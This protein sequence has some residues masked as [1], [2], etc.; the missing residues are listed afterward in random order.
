VRTK[1]GES[2][3]KETQDLNNQNEE[4]EEDISSPLNY[5]KNRKVVHEE[6]DQDINHPDIKYSQP[7]DADEDS[8]EPIKQKKGHYDLHSFKPSSTKK[9][10]PS[11]KSSQ[12]IKS[13]SRKYP[14]TKKKT[15]NRHSSHRSS[16]RSFAPSQ[17]KS[18]RGKSTNFDIIEVSEKESAENHPKELV[19]EQEYYEE[20]QHSDYVRTYVHDFD[21]KFYNNGRFF[22]AE[23]VDR[24]ERHHKDTVRNLD[25]IQFVKPYLNKV[26]GS[27]YTGKAKQR[28]YYDPGTIASQEFIDR[29][30]YDVINRAYLRGRKRYNTSYP[31]YGENL[32]GQMSQNRV[33][34]YSTKGQEFTQFSDTKRPMGEAEA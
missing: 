29:A 30:Y 19:E 31:I 28:A 17:T 10:S 27:Y 13:R 20:D 3:N 6:D 16:T 11:L 21:T 26:H 14:S 34:L 9:V 25:K 24:V 12:P 5:R 23:M 7:E 33:I 22:H 2:A 8:K 32:H 4:L 18:R 1:E 15:F